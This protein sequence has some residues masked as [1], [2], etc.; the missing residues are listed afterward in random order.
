[1]TSEKVTVKVLSSASSP[2]STDCTRS[3]RASSRRPARTSTDAS[4]LRALDRS[5]RLSNRPPS[6]SAVVRWARA[7]SSLPSAISTIPTVSAA[8]ATNGSFCRLEAVERHRG[9]TKRAVEVVDEGQDPGDRQLRGALEVRVVDVPHETVEPVD[10][11]QGALVI[12]DLDGRDGGG[13]QQLGSSDVVQ[14]VGSVLHLVDPGTAL[15]HAA[16]HLP[17]QPQ[18]AEHV[19]EWCDVVREE[20]ADGDPEVLLV[21]PQALGPLGL[22]FRGP[23]GVRH[24]RTEVLGVPPLDV[25][26]ILA[27]GEALGGELPHGGQHVEPRPRVNRVDGDEAVPCQRVEQIERPVLGE[28]GDVHRGLDRPP[29]DEDRQR[30]QHPLLGFVEE[31]EAPLDGRPQRSLPFG[32]VD[33][34]GAQRVE[35]S[36]QPREQRSWLQ[37]PGPSGG[38]LD[39]ERET[40]DEPADL[41]D[42]DDVVLGQGEAVADRLRPIDEELHGRQRGQL[43][44]RRSVRE[45]GHGERVDRVLAF[46]P[47]AKDGAARREDPNTRAASQELIERGR[48]THDLFQ[49]VQHEEGRLV[50]EVLDQDVQRRS[51]ALHRRTHRGR[52]A[53]QHQLGRVDRGERHEG[54]PLREAV[55]QSLTHGDREP[56][57][58]DAAWAG[59]GDQAHLG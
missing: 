22:S 12:A 16:P 11:G 35:A 46:G 17:E 53:G 43:V 3:A 6:S 58:A 44:G 13:E 49:V 14:A 28:V 36:F 56:R 27:V 2:A 50:R 32:E 18:D 33:R 31:P 4:W 55:V 39:G 23:V 52:D 26:E 47:Q 57:L 38:Q 30:G 8:N 45:R 37:H 42:G 9:G 59:E 54:R 21:R 15:G 40:V 19:R 41:R 5:Q 29:V 10:G 34:A 25:G 51:R 48:D 20:P 7:A 24:Q 1:M